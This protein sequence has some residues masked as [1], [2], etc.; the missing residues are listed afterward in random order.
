MHRECNTGSVGICNEINLG[1][2]KK[3]KKKK[4]HHPHEPNKIIKIK[5]LITTPWKGTSRKL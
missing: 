4:K 2:T 3:K 5:Q 1:S